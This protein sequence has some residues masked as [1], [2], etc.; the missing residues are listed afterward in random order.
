VGWYLGRF[1]DGVRHGVGKKV[2]IE[3]DIS[4]DG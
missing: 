2:K 4:N 3:T 1:E